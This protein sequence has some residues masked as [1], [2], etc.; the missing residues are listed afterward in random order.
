MCLKH[1]INEIKLLTSDLF[2]EIDPHL[3]DITRRNST[4][5]KDI[6][7]VSL[8]LLLEEVKDC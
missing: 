8:L 2:A 5:W 4:F 6:N 7:S 1:Q 3:N